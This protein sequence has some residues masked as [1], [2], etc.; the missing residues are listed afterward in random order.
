MTPYPRLVPTRKNGTELFHDGPDA[1]PFALDGFWQW[2]VSDLLSNAT[3]GRLAEYL[4]AR[5][6]GIDVDTTVRDEW[7]ACDL[8]TPEGVR[9]E[10]KSSAY[11]QAWYQERLSPIAF[12]V[13]PTRAWN[14]D[15]NTWAPDLCRQANFYVFALLTHTDQATVNPMD[16]SQWQFYLLP[17]SVLDVRSQKKISL[18]ALE[19]HTTPLTFNELTKAI[20]KASAAFATRCLTR[21]CGCRRLAAAAGGQ[22]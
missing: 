3:R 4:V 11:L 20:A 6:I 2:S 12:G 19:S 16:V 17:T 13:P 8:R 9:I 5:A 10:V 7:D 14:P 21:T 1:L 15:D 22:N 18:Q